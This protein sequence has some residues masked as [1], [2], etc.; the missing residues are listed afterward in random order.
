[1]SVGQLKDGSTEE[2]L[3]KGSAVPC[4]FEAPIMLADEESSVRVLLLQEGEP[5]AKLVMKDLDENSNLTLTV[6][7]T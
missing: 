6:E 7:V 3:P 5:L 4:R 2:I 1:M